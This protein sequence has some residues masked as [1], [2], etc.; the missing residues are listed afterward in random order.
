MAFNIVVDLKDTSLHVTNN[1]VNDDQSIYNDEEDGEVFLEE[2]QEKYN[3]MYTKW[4]N[5]FEINKTLKKNL[6]DAQ[7]QNKSL[8]QRNYELV[9]QVKDVT[10]RLNLAESRITCMNTG[11]AKLDEMLQAGRP[12]WLKTAL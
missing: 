5:F 3:L 2:L 11:K 8:E 4:V 1:S 6:L 9:A 12:T 7:K 10:K